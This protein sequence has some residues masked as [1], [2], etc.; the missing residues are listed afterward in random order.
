[1]YFENSFI[2]QSIQV[3]KASLR[4]HSIV[5]I[6]NNGAANVKTIDIMIAPII[7]FTK[8]SFGIFLFFISSCIN[9]FALHQA[10][11]KAAGEYQNI[12][13]AIYTKEA[14]TIHSNSFIRSG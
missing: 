7:A 4:Y 13:I 5:D 1:M 11:P 2:A 14:R 12:P 6:S 8:E 9:H 3:I 10:F